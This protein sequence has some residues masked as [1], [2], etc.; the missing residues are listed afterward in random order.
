VSVI[1]PIRRHIS[2]PAKLVEFFKVRCLP[3]RYAAFTADVCFP[4]FATHKLSCSHVDTTGIVCPPD[5]H[6][7]LRKRSYFLPE[8]AASRWTP[9]KTAEA[10]ERD[11]RP[12]VSQGRRSKDAHS[13]AEKAELGK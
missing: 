5:G 12:A 10:E 7:I 13:Q 1:G 2:S 8:A 11:R 3:T 9:D 4:S 6:T